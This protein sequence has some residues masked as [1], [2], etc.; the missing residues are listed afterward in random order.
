MV[1]VRS[2]WLKGP[3]VQIRVPDA[4]FYPRASLYPAVRAL[5]F[6]VRVKMRSAH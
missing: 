6:G 2:F 3:V 1:E 4:L 5:D